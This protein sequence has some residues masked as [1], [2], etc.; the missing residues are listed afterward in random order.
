M[1]FHLRAARPTADY[2]KVLLTM[3]TGSAL[4]GH[5]VQGVWFDPKRKK[6]RQ[7]RDREK[8]ATK[9]RKRR[10]RWTEEGEKEDEGR[11]EEKKISK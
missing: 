6:K 2:W 5:R 3:M 8:R 9:K 1:F 11:D 10:K 7:V 4:L